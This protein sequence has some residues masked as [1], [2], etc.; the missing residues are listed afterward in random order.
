MLSGMVYGNLGK[1][2]MYRNGAF[3]GENTTPAEP[4]NFQP[5]LAANEKYYFGGPGP[6]GDPNRLSFPMKIDEVRIYSGATTA[7]GDG[8][9][10]AIQIAD[11]VS[12]NIWPSAR[13]RLYW[14]FARQS[15]VNIDDD[16]TVP[17]FPCNGC[18]GAA[19]QDTQRTTREERK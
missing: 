8:A 2:T 11:G 14:S 18:I 10:T 17:T 12:L 3:V 19:R 1:V 7:A 15:G 16:A 13:L 6:I 9:L 4:Y 5:T